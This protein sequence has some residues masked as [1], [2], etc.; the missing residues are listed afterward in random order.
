MLLRFN[1]AIEAT[2]TFRRAVDEDPNDSTRRYNLAVALFSAGDRAGAMHQLET[3]IALEPMLEEAYVLAAEIQPN[4]ASEWKQR[5]LKLAPQ[6]L[7]R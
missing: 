1:K 6:R 3:A 4:R 5:Y 2:H 7:F